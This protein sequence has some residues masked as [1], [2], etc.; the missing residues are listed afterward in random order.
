MHYFAF[1]LF[2]FLFTWLVVTA[3][4]R[5][6]VVAVTVAGVLVL[7]LVVAPPAAQ[8]QGDLLALIEAVLNAI[9]GVIQTALE[10][11]QHRPDA[12]NN[13]LPEH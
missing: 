2:L 5:R 1:T 9:N 8:A 13:L 7:T 6:R 4:S 3:N 12:I 11:D 10:R